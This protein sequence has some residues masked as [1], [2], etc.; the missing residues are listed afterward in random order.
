MKSNPLRITG[1]FFLGFLAGLSFG[2]GVL[3]FAV[4]TALGIPSLDV[5]LD[6]D[7]FTV[8]IGVVWGVSA[9]VLGRFGGLRLG[10]ALLG[11]CGLAS[12]LFLGFAALGGSALPLLVASV[13][14][15]V[16]GGSGG[17]LLG[18]IFPPPCAVD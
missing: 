9:A 18:K 16:Y 1:A 6:V 3:P 11:V 13:T 5:L 7:R 2:T 14:G 12:G 15:T 4:S 8:P 10:L 17:L